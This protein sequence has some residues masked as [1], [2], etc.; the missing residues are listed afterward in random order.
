MG[1][2]EAITTTPT[3]STSARR[4]VLLLAGCQAL[5]MTGYILGV[6]TSAL[7]GAQL[8]SRPSLATL[9]LALQF[10][11]MTLTTVPASLLMGKL[12]RRFGFMLAAA[13]G[14][15][16]AVLATSAILAGRFWLFI[17]ASMLLGIFYGFAGYYRFAAAD[18][19]TD[20][21]RGRAISYTMAGGVVAAFGGPYL[22]RG[23]QH[24]MGSAEFA[25]SY[26][27]LIA[28]FLLALLLP[29]G[30]RLPRPPAVRFR[31]GRP[32]ATIARQ[33][34]FLVALAGG[35]FGFAI[36]ILVMTATPL[37]M[38]ALQYGFGSTAIVF[39]WH[40]LG[41]FA[42]SFATG[43]LIRRFGVH[44][45]M[46]TGGLLALAA[47]AVNLGARG[48]V[49]WFWLGLL[50]LGVAWNF[51]FIGGTNLLTEAYRPE[52]KAKTQALNDF[53]VYGAVAAASLSA[54]ALEHGYGWRA[55]NLVVLPFIAVV[56]IAILSLR[57]RRRVGP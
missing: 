3:P 45:I 25:G 44:N 39:Q 32:L 55:V 7:V 49:V 17:L 26:A 18:A 13:I 22:A 9:P 46:L 53:L 38:K 14:V 37:A 2:A 10:L 47:V 11:A 51:L 35:M 20:D 19:A 29:A 40:V 16:G 21:F 54:A 56:V 31:A 23:L 6:A 34:V 4:N 50:L 5:Y 48:G 27:S 52:E 36:M 15:G 30:L 24:V 41:M 43:H 8:A 33:P 1:A 28:I 42:P 57:T 12:G